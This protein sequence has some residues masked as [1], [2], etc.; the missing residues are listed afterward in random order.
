MEALQR[1][2]FSAH[3]VEV[4][5][6]YIGKTISNVVHYYWKNKMDS[7][8]I[9]LLYAVE[10]FFDD[11]DFVVIHTGNTEEDA[12]IR[13]SDTDMVSEKIAIENQ[14]NGAITL[15]GV[16]VGKEEPWSIMR[17]KTII[18]MEAD[19][20]KDTQRFFADYLIFSSKEGEVLLKIGE[21]GDGL[22]VH[23]FYRDEE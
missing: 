17:G 21:F 10:L 6:S 15:D 5:E 12:R 13:F 22:E 23:P 8:G 18:R 3:E 1:P 9:T 19:L 7:E 11:N 16:D 4:V 20:D 2:H 14:F